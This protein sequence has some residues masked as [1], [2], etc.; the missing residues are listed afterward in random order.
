MRGAANNVNGHLVEPAAASASQWQ[1][2]SAEFSVIYDEP[3]VPL[4][5]EAAIAKLYGSLYSSI[6]LLAIYDSL[7]PDVCSWTLQHGGKPVAIFLFHARSS[8]ATVINEGMRVETA[9]A[10]EFCRWVFA[11]FPRVSAVRF[12]NVEWKADGKLAYPCQHFPSLENIVL[13]LPASQEEYHASLSKNLRRNLKRYPER[14]LR[15]YPDYH[16]EFISGDKI[17]DSDVRAIVG[18]NIERMA[19]KHKQSAYDDEETGR[20]LR[21]VRQCGLVGV[22][23]IGGRVAAGAIS[24]VTGENVALSILAHD[25][26]YND[27]SLGILCAFQTIQHCIGRGAR[28]FH[29]LW[30]RYDY[31]FLLGARERPLSRVVI[32][33]SWLQAFTH[34]DLWLYHFSERLKRRGGE[35]LHQMAHSHSRAARLAV[36]SLDNVRGL[37]Q[38]ARRVCGRAEK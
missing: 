10:R 14:L 6:P 19:S 13:S 35:R 9:H 26:V 29:F 8:V 11:H 32:Y 24:F 3:L 23:R 4:R 34:V 12:S 33:R 16:C 20:I 25:P 22:A 27:Y 28:E 18:L 21:L 5:V 31:K 37:R 15:D 17:A 36:S 7:T 30:G 38:L 2:E 1:C